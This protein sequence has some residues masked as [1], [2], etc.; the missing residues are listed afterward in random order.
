MRQVSDKSILKVMAK[1]R[2]RE[3]RSLPSGRVV[4]LI[5][6]VLRIWQVGES[7]MCLVGD[8]TGLM[9]IGLGKRQVQEGDVYL[10]EGLIVCAYTGG[11]HSFELGDY[12]RIH[13]S[14]GPISVA[15]DEKYIQQVYKI[16]TGLEKKRQT[17]RG[18]DQLI[19]PSSRMIAASQLE[20][21]KR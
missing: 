14:D 9:R 4:S 6:K 3:A 10:F 18:Q 17:S 21:N 19:S 2:V 11:W 5:A 20:N 13:A 15:A 7:K 8:E 12:G 1:V 16:L